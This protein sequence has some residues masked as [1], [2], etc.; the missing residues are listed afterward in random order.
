MPI[1]IDPVVA[2]KRKEWFLSKLKEFSVTAQKIS[3]YLDTD[4]SCVSN[5]KTGKYAIRDSVY[6]KLEE[7][8]NKIQYERP[9]KSVS[10]FRR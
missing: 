3:D 9:K 2:E 5:W 6:K 4:A 10:P 8:F 7:Y 1:A